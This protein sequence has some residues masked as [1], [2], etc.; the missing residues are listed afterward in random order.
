MQLLD[1]GFFGPLKCIYGQEY[2][3]WMIINPQIQVS[4][5]FG[6]AYASVANIQ[7]AQ[8]SF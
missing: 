8:K 6:A 7:K 3:N 4:R 2:D 5:L 1:I